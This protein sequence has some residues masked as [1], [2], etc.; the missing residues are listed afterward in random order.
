MPLDCRHRGPRA[1][2]RKPQHGA[3][4]ARAR[5]LH[6]R[7]ALP[8][9][10]ERHPL[11][12]AA[13]PPLLP[14]RRVS[15]LPPPCPRLTRTLRPRQPRRR[16]S[17]PSTT[18]P[19]SPTSPSTAGRKSTSGRP[20][21]SVRPALACRSMS[22]SLAGCSCQS[23]RRS[24]ARGRRPENLAPNRPPVPDRDA[25]HG[26]AAL[27]LFFSLAQLRRVGCFIP[28]LFFL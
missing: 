11:G 2:P 28:D 20:T 13:S 6:H 18:A 17:A 22:T 23:A 27:V 7:R 4:R 16:A 1:E 15:L 21:L 9:V 5:P 24:T 3:H 19:P 14:P 12:A 26:G 8:N 10:H 25:T